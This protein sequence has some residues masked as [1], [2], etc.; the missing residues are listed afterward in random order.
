MVRASRIVARVCSST[1]STGPAPST[2]TVKSG[3]RLKDIALKFGVKWE[4]IA[5]LN[6]I[7]DPNLIFIGQ[8]LKLPSGATTTTTASA[9]T[10][11]AGKASL[12][13][14]RNGDTLAAI[15]GTFG[16]T[17]ERLMQINSISNQ[18]LLFVGQLIKL[19]AEATRLPDKV[20]HTVKAGD[21]LSLLSRTY[22]A[23]IAAIMNANGLT[24]DSLFPGQT[25]VIP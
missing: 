21:T 3:D 14:V 23:S 8:V 25:L 16:T 6:N 7:R 15:A 12:Y 17:I 20:V 5:S 4:D 9:G 19:P 10:V 11:P 22:G 13:A 24:N 2:Y 18:N 1:G